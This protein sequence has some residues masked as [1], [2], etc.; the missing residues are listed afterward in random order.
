MP[1][2]G[3]HEGIHFSMGYSGSG[4]ALAPYL[5][6]KAAYCAIG[7]SRGDTAYQHSIM[8]PRWFHR[9]NTPHFLIPANFWY[10]YAIDQFENRSAK[11]DHNI[12]S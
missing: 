2:V 12:G 7:D 9:I 6:A 10:K 4:V 8:E 1:Q 5:G 3:N 11:R